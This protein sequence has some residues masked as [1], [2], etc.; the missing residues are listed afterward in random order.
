MILHHSIYCGPDDRPPLLIAHGLFG[1]ARNWHGLA[2]RFSADRTVISV[3]MRNHGASKWSDVHDYPSMASDLSATLDAAGIDDSVLVLG[4]SMGGKAVMTLALGAPDRV[5]GLIVADIAPVAYDHSHDGF[6][7]AMKALDLS[8]VDRRSVA[9]KALA[10]AIAD[11]AVRA[12]LLQN[13]EIRQEGARWRI[14]L[15]VLGR[16]M[17]TLTGWPGELAGRRFE[18]PSLFLHGGASDY[19]T[20]TAHPTLKG[21]FPAATITALSGA[22]HWLHAEAPDAFHDAV[23]GWFSAHGF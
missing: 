22:G 23:T 18:G 11:R 6:V 20:A 13:L 3:D 10:P 21:L 17:E 14:N 15:D 1:S 2:N 8:G 19:V 5:A 16:A 4:H 9:D 12:F 7:E